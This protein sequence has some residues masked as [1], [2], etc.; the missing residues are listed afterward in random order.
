MTKP[1]RFAD[2]LSE[3]DNEYLP[4]KCFEDVIYDNESRTKSKMVL[5]NIYDRNDNVL[6]NCENRK[7]ARYITSSLNATY[8]SKKVQSIRKDITDEVLCSFII[9]G[10][11]VPKSEK[12]YPYTDEDGIIRFKKSKVYRDYISKAIKNKEWVYRAQERIRNVD[13]YLVALFYVKSD[14]NLDIGECLG[15][16][17][18]VITES[19]MVKRDNNVRLIGIA[20]AQMVISKDNQR[21][22]IFVMRNTTRERK[23]T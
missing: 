5:Y 17:T 3:S 20:K 4:L 11:V 1:V 12:I 15:T 2:Y 18:D 19:G 13:I 8:I 16:I 21:T 7:Q 23:V 10:E 22:E 6:C 14:Y 9:D